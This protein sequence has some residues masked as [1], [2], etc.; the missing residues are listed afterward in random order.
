MNSCGTNDLN[1]GVTQSNAVL[2]ATLDS[3]LEAK[4]NSRVSNTESIS[5]EGRDP[6]CYI[7]GRSALTPATPTQ[8]EL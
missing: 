6:W 4:G 3:F 7:Q 8:R 5:Q 1:L 2:P